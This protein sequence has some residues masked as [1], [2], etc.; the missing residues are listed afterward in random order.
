MA[1]SSSSLIAA[2]RTSLRMTKQMRDKL[3]ILMD[4]LNFP[5]QDELIT[6][7]V[8]SASVSYLRPHAEKYLGKLAIENAKRKQKEEKARL[9]A[10]SL[11]PE[12]LDAILKQVSGV[13]AQK[14]E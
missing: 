2:K 9:I 4:E 12:Q 8:E 7:L 10:S 6:F 1:G 5:S 11:S 3:K 14:Q 13:S